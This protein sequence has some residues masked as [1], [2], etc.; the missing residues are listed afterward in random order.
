MAEFHSIPKVSI[1]DDFHD[2]AIEY[3]SL[4]RKRE[5][6]SRMGGLK[7]KLKWLKRMY[8]QSKCA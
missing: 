3:L 8:A 4:R 1:D 6:W 5:M 2:F 7:E